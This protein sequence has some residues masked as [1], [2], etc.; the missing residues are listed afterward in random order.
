MTET[1]LLP[2][3]ANKAGYSFD[4]MVEKM[5]LGAFESKR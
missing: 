2:K 3:A 5:L 1:S 4:D